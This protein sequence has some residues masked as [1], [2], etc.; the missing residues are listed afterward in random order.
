[1]RSVVRTIILN[2]TGFFRTVESGFTLALG[3][4]LYLSM[5]V[6]RCVMMETRQQQQ[7]SDTNSHYMLGIITHTSPSAL[8]GSIVPFKFVS[9]ISYRIPQ[10]KDTPLAPSVR[11]LHPT[12]P[13]FQHHLMIVINSKLW[14]GSNCLVISTL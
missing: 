12:N 5:T 13:I 10:T 1:M 3:G 9:T 11:Y 2:G 7:Y 6:S 14:A 8:P 4:T